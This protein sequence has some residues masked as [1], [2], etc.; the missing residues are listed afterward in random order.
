MKI[1]SRVR[2]FCATL[3]ILGISSVVLSK[4]AVSPAPGQ[5]R[6]QDLKWIRCGPSRC[7]TIG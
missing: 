4:R 1:N 6:R 5:F 3:V 7:R 2:A